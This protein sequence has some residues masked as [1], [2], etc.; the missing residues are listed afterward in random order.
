MLMRIIGISLI[1]L[2]ALNAAL[3]MTVETCTQGGAD[4]LSAGVLT[5][6]LYVFGTAAL[7]ASEP[8]RYTLLALAPS[9]MIAVWHSIFAVRF[10]AGYWFFD[11]S[12]C[13]AMA[14]AFSAD[15]AGEWMD[16]DEPYYSILWLALS[17]AYWLCAFLTFKA[18]RDH[19]D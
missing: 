13:S 6:A 5:L 16:G 11:I 15:N 2:G 1:T 10:F 14:G 19:P 12:A 9:A 7:I 18:S 17:A 8:P 4:S 3:G